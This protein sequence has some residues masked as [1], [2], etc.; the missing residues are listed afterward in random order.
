MLAHDA[1]QRNL[2]T[3]AARGVRFVEPGEGYL[4]CGWIG[5][6]RLAE[7]AESSP[8]PRRCW[9]RSGFAAARPAHRRHA[10]GRPTKTSIP[11]A[12]SAT[13][14]AG[15]WGLRWR[16]KR[17]GGARRRDARGRA[18]AHRAAGRSTSSSACAAPPRCTRRSCARRGGRRCRHH[19]GRRRR[20]HAGA[21]GVAEQGGEGRRA[22]D[23]DPRADA[24]TSWP[25]SAG[26]P[27]APT[28]RPMLVGFAAETGDAVARAREKRLRKG[29]D[30]IVANDV[31][32]SRTPAST[33]RPMP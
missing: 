10:R 30:L 31:S 8:R 27:R 9:R 20:L 7:P 28:G 19:G 5:K 33:S 3:L 6:G 26:C 18:D 13:D 4:A 25:S 22:D 23:A 21:S 16:R 12:T 11:C 29:I 17:S 14:R 2:Q 15:A 24:A 1:V 32:R